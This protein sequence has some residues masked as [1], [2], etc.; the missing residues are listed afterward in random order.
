ML[1]LVPL[2][3]AERTGGEVQVEARA[4]AVLPGLLGADPRHAQDRRQHEQPEAGVV[5]EPAIEDA[6]LVLRL[7]PD[8]VV[9]VAEA[10]AGAFLLAGDLDRT[11]VA[12]T[13]P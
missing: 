9:L 4:L 13:V 12:A 6:L 10:Q 3:E 5:P 11:N 7:D 2:S 1:L 8:A